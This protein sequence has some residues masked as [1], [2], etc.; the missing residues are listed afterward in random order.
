MTPAE[1]TGGLVSTS[2][3]LNDLALL[4]HPQWYSSLTPSEEFHR[5]AL[6]GEGSYAELY[7]AGL[8]NR[9]YNFL[10]T[11]FSYFQFYY[12]QLRGR[13]E[14]RYAFYPNPF[15]VIS[16]QI[17]CRQFECDPGEPDS[18]DLYLQHLD[19]LEERDLVPPLRYEVSFTQFNELVH[20]TAHLHVGLHG[21]SRWPVERIL[22]P[23]AFALFISKHFY[24]ES[25]R[26]NGRPKEG[27]TDPTNTFDIRYFAAKASS[28]VVESDYF[29]GQERRQMFLS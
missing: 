4:H 11:D 9:D 13:F 14:L 26:D 17:F 23:E 10:L 2:I 8:R 3:A 15:P 18:H 21:S 12:Q 16:F 28:Q 7:R 25:W 27:S 20:P 24:H 1:F 5:L 29:T 19:E 22:L 6:R